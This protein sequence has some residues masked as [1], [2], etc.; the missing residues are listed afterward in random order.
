[1]YIIEA[2]E[3]L[4][5]WLNLTKSI[6]INELTDFKKGLVEN[7]SYANFGNAWHG[8]TSNFSESRF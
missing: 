8:V 6:Y 5:I 2:T 3:R 4:D 1:M 7:P